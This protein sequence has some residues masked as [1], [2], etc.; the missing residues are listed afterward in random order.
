M[1]GAVLSFVHDLQS[2]SMA[3][4]QIGNIFVG[5]SITQ[6]GPYVAPVAQFSMLLE[7]LRFVNMKWYNYRYQFCDHPH[8]F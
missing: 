2:I 5:T 7:V 1:D 8:K 6:V 4:Q 3:T